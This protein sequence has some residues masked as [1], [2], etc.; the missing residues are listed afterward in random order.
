MMDESRNEI[1]SS[2][3]IAHLR[4]RLSNEQKLSGGAQSSSLEDTDR[5]IEHIRCRLIRGVQQQPAEMIYHRFKS[6]LSQ[7][8]NLRFSGCR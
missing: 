7:R 8:C 4:F 6:D 1:L 2:K 3:A 5:V